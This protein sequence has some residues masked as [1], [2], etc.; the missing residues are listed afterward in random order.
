MPPSFQLFIPICH[1]V[2]LQYDKSSNGRCLGALQIYDFT[3]TV[4]SPLHCSGKSVRENWL[5]VLNQQD[6]VPDA[7]MTKWQEFITATVELLQKIESVYKGLS[8]QLNNN[9]PGEAHSAKDEF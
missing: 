4:L 5:D 1:F 6:T 9:T 2:I 8:F 7:E 3:K